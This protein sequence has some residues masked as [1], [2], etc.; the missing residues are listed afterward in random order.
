MT[1]KLDENLPAELVGDLRAAGHDA[2]TVPQQDLAGAPDSVVIDRVRTEGRVLLT[3]DKGIA[4]A[5]AYP[6]ERYGGIILFRPRSS[7]RAAVVSFVRRHLPA[8]LQADLVGHFLVVSDRGIR[9]R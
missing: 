5:R 4:N 6:P 8:L 7:G 2:Q 1:F 3:M 9:I